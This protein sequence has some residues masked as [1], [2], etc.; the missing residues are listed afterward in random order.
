[1]P[2][3]AGELLV[4][5]ELKKLDFSRDGHVYVERY[6]VSELTNI[7]KLMK[8]KR[9]FRHLLK[10]PEDKMRHLEKP[11]VDPQSRIKLETTPLTSSLKMV[12]KVQQVSSSS[13]SDDSEESNDEDDV[14][15]PF[16]DDE[17]FSKVFKPIRSSSLKRNTS[18]SNVPS[19]A[20]VNSSRLERENTQ[21]HLGSDSKANTTLRSTKYLESDVDEETFNKTFRRV[22]LFP[23]EKDDPVDKSS[24]S[25]AL[26]TAKSYCGAS[27]LFDSMSIDAKE[28]NP[29]TGVF[30]PPKT[31]DQPAAHKTEESLSVEAAAHSLV[32]SVAN[33]EKEGKPNRVGEELLSVVDPFAS[34]CL[35]KYLKRYHDFKAKSSDLVSPKMKLIDPPET[36]TDSTPSVSSRTSSNKDRLSQAHKPLT[37][38]NDVCDDNNPLRKSKIPKTLPCIAEKPEIPP[39]TESQPSATNVPTSPPAQGMMP[40]S[41]SDDLMLH[42]V[43]ARTHQ[44]WQ[45]K[46]A[47][48]LFRRS[49]LFVKKGG[50]VSVSRYAPDFASVGVTQNSAIYAASA[51]TSADRLVTQEQVQEQRELR[52]RLTTAEDSVDTKQ[53]IDTHQSEVVTGNEPSSAAIKQTKNAKKDTTETKGP[54]NSVISTQ[55]VQEINDASSDKLAMTRRGRTIKRASRFTDFLVGDTRLPTKR[56]EKL[57]ER[58]V[59]KTIETC[60][61]KWDE[62]QDV[63]DR[64]QQAMM[65]PITQNT[66][67]LTS[68]TK[69]QQKSPIAGSL[70]K[71]SDRDSPSS[72]DP[73]MSSGDEAELDEQEVPEQKFVPSLNEVTHEAQSTNEIPDK[74]DSEGQYP[75][76]TIAPVMFIADVEAK[77]ATESPKAKTL[78]LAPPSQRSPR[79]N[80]SFPPRASAAPP[81]PS[82]QAEVQ[83]VQKVL[84]NPAMGVTA[85]EELAAIV[86]LSQ[87]LYNEPCT[88]S[89]EQLMKDLKTS[90][91]IELRNHEQLIR[92]KKFLIMRKLEMRA[93]LRHLREIHK[94]HCPLPH[95]IT[96]V[97]RQQALHGTMALAASGSTSNKITPS[98]HPGLKPSQLTSLIQPGE[99]VIV[100]PS[101]HGRSRCVNAGTAT[102]SA[103]GHVVY[104]P[105]NGPGNLSVT[106]VSPPLLAVH[107]IGAQ[108]NPVVPIS[109]IIPAGQRFEVP[110]S[111]SPFLANHATPHRHVVSAPISKAGLRPVP[112]P[113]GVPVVTQGLSRTGKILL[114]PIG[115][116]FAGS[117]PRIIRR[118]IPINRTSNGT[119]VVTP[120]SLPSMASNG[121]AQSRPGISLLRKLGSNDSGST[122]ASLLPTSQSA[123]YISTVNGR[124]PVA[125]LRLLNPAD[126]GMQPLGG[127]TAPAETTPSNSAETSETGIA[128]N[129]AA[130]TTSL[131]RRKQSL[132][133]SINF[134][135]MP[136]PLGRPPK[137]KASVSP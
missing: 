57:K 37:Y 5:N 61:Q 70:K 41:S 29:P 36:S 120:L 93:R 60:P 129:S 58:R 14:E 89:V 108:S 3:L 68:I 50:R 136:P 97:G 22:R 15:E 84:I 113:K 122:T 51:L 63:T 2:S 24:M 85:S 133:P 128:R 59:S 130:S 46:K 80:E 65:P 16:V 117:P 116:S 28:V 19:S 114:K 43:D 33:S 71:S 27:I 115:G 72:I 13:S 20:L 30:V 126:D 125:Y 90:F 42:T 40:E 48:R 134:D 75:D 52:Q 6:T 34:T 79:I 31:N 67:V 131:Q 95:R 104:V 47:A 88:V 99:P 86:E 111:V 87:M 118:L 23:V 4:K 107:P 69:R 9:A 7:A 106:K 73:F 94:K 44:D 62:G 49:L 91:S 81:A 64:Q 100:V 105:Q 119:P 12:I 53:H 83:R 101:L 96:Y 55:V 39:T 45:D 56:S 18:S 38:L 10:R 25:G 32:K 124:P 21:R 103:K 98:R 8:S 121:V 76:R 112:A 132:K 66:E 127:N 109:P 137:A 17:I 35:Q 82:W 11:L 77:L 92:W 102:S 54:A 110:T 78:P 26:A 123:S 74:A 135:L 1:M